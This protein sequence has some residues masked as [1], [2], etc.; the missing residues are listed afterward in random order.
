MVQAA[1]QVKHREEAG[2]HQ[3]GC[4]VSQQV[5]ASVPNGWTETVVGAEMQKHIST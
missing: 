1:R 2:M 5:N 4:S 3:R